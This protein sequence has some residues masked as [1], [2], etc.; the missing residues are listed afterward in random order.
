MTARSGASAVRLLMVTF[1]VALVVLFAVPIAVGVVTD[2]VGWGIIVGLVGALAALVVG[3]LLLARH[4]HA[5]WFL[6][7]AFARRF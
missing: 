2:S 5:K 1:V 6:K 3:L 4:G 7:R